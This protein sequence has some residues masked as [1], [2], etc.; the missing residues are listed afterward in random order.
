MKKKQE[1]LLED[2]LWTLTKYIGDPTVGLPGLPD[3]FMRN[4]VVEL[5]DIFRPK[6]TKRRNFDTRK[7]S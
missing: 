6:K 1:K 7:T 5:A 4:R 2:Y 3:D